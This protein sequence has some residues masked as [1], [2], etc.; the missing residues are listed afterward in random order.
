MDNQRNI[1]KQVFIIKWQNLLLVGFHLP[2]DGGSYATSQWKWK[3]LQAWRIRVNGIEENVMDIT[4][5]L[6]FLFC[7]MR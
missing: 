7:H 2:H 6:K 5:T 1:Q 4:E 3:K